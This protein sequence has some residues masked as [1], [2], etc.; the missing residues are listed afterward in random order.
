MFDTK[1]TSYSRLASTIAKS[2]EDVEASGS[3]ERWRDV[4]IEVED[5][6]EKV[7]IIS[8]HSLIVYCLTLTYFIARGIEQCVTRA[9]EQFRDA[10]AI[11]VDDS[12]YSTSS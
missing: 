7:K 8:N 2:S 12:R 5:L 9:F 4:E 6:L 11:T 10:P 1:L 3:R